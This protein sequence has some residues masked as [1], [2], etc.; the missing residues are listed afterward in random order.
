MKDETLY[1]I[2][3]LGIILFFTPFLPVLSLDSH[4]LSAT[5]PR[6]YGSLTQNP[7]TMLFRGCHQHRTHQ[8][9]H[10]NSPTFSLVHTYFLP[11]IKDP[12]P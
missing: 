6:S 5:D 1:S 3:R 4:F 10:S 12:M 8:K 11:L 7:T 2:I 9:Q